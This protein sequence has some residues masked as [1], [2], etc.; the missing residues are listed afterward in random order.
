MSGTT[1]IDEKVL[2]MPAMGAGLHTGT[3]LFEGDAIVA[4]GIDGP[5]T[6]QVDVLDE[7]GSINDQDEHV[8]D[9]YLA[10]EFE[11]PIIELL[12]YAD[13]AVDVNGNAL[14]DF[15]NI[16]ITFDVAEADDYT[17][18]GQLADS[19][20]V[21]IDVVSAAGSYPSGTSVATLAFNGAKI[22]EH[23]VDGP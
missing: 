7:T 12:S 22:F 9:P 17:L 4:S 18:T 19:S 1:L 5:Y 2:S 10:S 8:T 3:V 15:L 14:Y 11:N 21:L 23:G 13:S 20:G 16:N 6:V